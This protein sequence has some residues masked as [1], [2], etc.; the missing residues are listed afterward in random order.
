M[1]TE[2]DRLH[3]ITAKVVRADQHIQD[4]Q[5]QHETFLTA[6]PY[7]IATKRDPETRR[8]IYYLS[9]ALAPEDR[10]A[11]TLGDI[12][13]NLISALDH[14]A[15]QLVCVG[16]ATDGPHPH[17]YFPI[18][19]DYAKYEAT[20]NA[21]TKGMRPDAIKAIDAIRPYRGGNDSLWKLSKLNNIDKHRLIITIGSA[22]HSVNIA[23]V[24]NRGFEESFPQFGPL[25]VFDL[26]LKPG[27]RLFPLKTGDELF[28]DAPDAKPN[29]TIK[30]RF[31]VAFGERG[32]IEGE[33]LIKTVL[34]FKSLV[35]RIISEFEPLLV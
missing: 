20:K 4:L 9:Q 5:T 34:E 8:L 26:Y 30:F 12:L 1:L 7:K 13:Q 27:D 21:R 10:M 23:P 18:A 15:Y 31:E 2:K 25:P 14:L 17:V 32:I 11:T 19:D 33:P 28:I 3:H 22:Y 35:A 16:T 29:A 6:N 24:L